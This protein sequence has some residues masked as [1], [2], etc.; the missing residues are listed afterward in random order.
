MATTS[1]VDDRAET[2]SVLVVDDDPVEAHSVTD[3]LEL[4]D[5]AITTA[6]ATDP[7]AAVAA[8]TDGGVDCV[9]TAADLGGVSGFD[10]LDRVATTDETV[11]AVVHTGEDDPAIAREAWHR[12]AAYAKKGADRERYDVLAD[13]LTGRTETR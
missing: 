4:A 1:T 12:G 5:S 7:D 10:V 6:T 8:V 9:V 2:V 11:R 13:H 3:S